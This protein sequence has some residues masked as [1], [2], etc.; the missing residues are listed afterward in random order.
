MCELYLLLH[1]RS[2][3]TT[4]ALNTPP[5][6]Q[7]RLGDLRYFIVGAGAIGCELLKNLALVGVGAGIGGVGGL[8]ITD[9]DV[10]EKSNL[11]RQFLFRASDVT[12]AKSETAAAAAMAINP[13]LQVN[14]Y[15]LRV[16][17]ETEQVFNASFYESLDGVALALDNVEARRYMD[18]ACWLHRRP[19]LESGTLGL[20]G[21]VQPI[22]PGLTER[23]AQEQVSEDRPVAVCT[24][25]RFPTT[26][27][28]TLQWAR[29]VTKE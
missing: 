25:K 26:I 20:N 5:L 27:Q 24:L 23:Y 17:P 12:R 21:S 10:I 15:Q 22:L 6:L 8:T 7:E 11:S 2:E 19:I 18:H 29:C 28:H 4:P 14:T 16:G 13:A 1:P 9:M 3:R